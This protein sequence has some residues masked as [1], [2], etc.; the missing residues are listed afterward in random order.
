MQIVGLLALLLPVTIV[1]VGFFIA[2]RL[3]ARR[4]ED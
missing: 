4:G 1:G 2:N 3:R